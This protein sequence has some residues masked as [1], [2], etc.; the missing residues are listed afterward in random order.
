MSHFC[1]MTRRQLVASFTAMATTAS[2]GAVAAVRNAGAGAGASSSVILGN[3]EYRYQVVGDWGE[4]PKWCSW[5]TELLGFGNC[6][7]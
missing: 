6:S 2:L 5:E 7:V 4:L 3:G 1:S